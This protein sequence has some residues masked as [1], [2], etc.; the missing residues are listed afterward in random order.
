MSVQEDFILH[1]ILSF[2][3]IVEVDCGDASSNITLLNQYF[4]SGS[5]PPPQIRA[6]LVKCIAGYK[7]VDNIIIKNMT[8]FG[9][10]NWFFATA[11]SR[12]FATFDYIHLL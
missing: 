10:G 11:C 3:N 7:W 9:T 8:C 2:D 6:G 1:K 12:I 5:S 4:L